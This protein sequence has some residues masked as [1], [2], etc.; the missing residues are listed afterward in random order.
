LFNPSQGAVSS[1]LGWGG[2]SEILIAVMSALL[3]LGAAAGAM[4]GGYTGNR[5]G[6][7]LTLLWGAVS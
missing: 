7:R 3:P 2:D 6:R 1:T 5:Y 4:I